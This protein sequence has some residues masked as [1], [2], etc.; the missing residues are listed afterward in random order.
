M[1]T[2]APV[3]N[4]TPAFIDELNANF[5]AI[6]AVLDRTID[7]RDFRVAIGTLE[8]QSTKLQAAIA[9]AE[10]AKIR[11]LLPAGYIRIDNTI[12]LG[13]NAPIWME[14]PLSHNFTGFTDNPIDAV[15][16]L[17]CANLPSNVPAIKFD[18]TVT[19]NT[20]DGIT[21][22]NVVIYRP[23]PS[24]AGAG[25]KGILLLGVT[26]PRIENVLVSGFDTG[27]HFNESTDGTRA[28]LMG[29]FTNLNVQLSG[30]YGGLVESC[31]ECLWD[32]CAFGGATIASLGIIAPTLIGPGPAN[33][34]SNGNYFEH[35]KFIASTGTVPPNNVRIDVGFW[36]NFDTCAF[37]QAT[38]ENF[39]SDMSTTGGHT[40]NRVDVVL[41]DCWFNN[42]FASNTGCLN[43]IDTNFEIIGG[44]AGSTVS[45]DSI[46]KVDIS[47][48][49][50]L[51]LGSCIMGMRVN[52]PAVSG[53]HLGNV[54][55]CQI[56]GNIIE[57]QS[58]S[59]LPCIV[60]GATSGRSAIS[61]NRFRTTHATGYTNG[62]EAV[63][64][65][66]IFVDN[67]LSNN[68]SSDAFYKKAIGGP[69]QT[70]GGQVAKWQFLGVDQASAERLIARYSADTG[71]PFT[72]YYKSRATAP[73]AARAAVSSGD[74]VSVRRFYADD[75][76][77]DQ[78]VFRETVNVDGVTGGSWSL[79]NK[80]AAGALTTR[81]TLDNA[82]VWT[83]T[84]TWNFTGNSVLTGSLTTT[85]T[86]TGPAGTTA[87]ATLRV[88]HGAAPTSPTNGDIW[89]TTAGLFVRIN[90]VTVGPLT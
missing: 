63:G 50:I 6:D 40:D 36:N 23:T 56:I 81:I 68:F 12:T 44:R 33:V 7:A 26:N 60:T 46:I 66:N 64:G 75:G 29:N 20:R 8:D 21:L 76:T 72:L 84:G 4:V 45:V 54:E 53:I 77:A 15:T 41:V 10:A 25:D 16:V 87:A 70:V 47:G 88:P 5:A 17:Y 22:K 43:L 35:C 57:D 39:K 80:I 48:V 86:I 52:F 14:G 38:G 61:A 3:S 11:L 69:V 27:V 67:V 24:T 37:E 30:N 78:E 79:A 2:I 31:I 42:D 9:A 62:S 51:T 32:H 49:N 55:G 73:G 18:Q 71:A 34:I 74:G 89:T 19:G 58:A 13:T 90:G 85:G 28:T 65:G 59:G 83:I 1:T 82:G